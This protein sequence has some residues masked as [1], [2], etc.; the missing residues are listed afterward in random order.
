MPEKERQ[1]SFTLLG[2]E[3]SVVTAASEKEMND[4]LFLVKNIMEDGETTRGTSTISISR[5]AVLASL[6]L[7]SRYLAVKDDFERFK[8]ESA[9]RLTLLAEEIEVRL[10]QAKNDKIV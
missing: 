5:K 8:K 3:Y 6:T 2:Q 9:A 10:D 1:F 4:I 7:A